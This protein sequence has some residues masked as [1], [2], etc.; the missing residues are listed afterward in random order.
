MSL[1]RMAI[2]GELGLLILIASLVLILL[3][4][5]VGISGMIS[6]MRPPGTHFLEALLIIFLNSFSALCTL[7]GSFNFEKS[8]SVMVL[9]LFQL[10]LLK[11]TNFLKSFLIGWMVVLILIIIGRWSE[12]RLVSVLH[13]TLFISDVEAIDMSGDVAEPLD[14]TLV[15][16]FSFRT[17]KGEFPIS[18]A[19]SEPLLS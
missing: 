12:P 5:A 4:V 2:S 7:V 10:A 15:G 13:S 8:D 14:G 11:L 9:N 1:L 17:P 6:F 16:V 3:A 19:N 18:S